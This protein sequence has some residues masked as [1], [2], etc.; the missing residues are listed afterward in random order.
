ML[1]E[2]HEALETR[3]LVL[4]L[5]DASRR[6]QLEGIAAQV[7]T[8]RRSGTPAARSTRRWASEDEFLFGLIRGLDCP[9]FL[10]LT[11]IDLVAKDKLLPLIESLTQQYNFAEVIP[12]SAR[13]RDGLDVLVRKIVERAAHGRALLS[14]RSIHRS[15]AALHGG[16][17]DSRTHSGRDR[18]RGSVRLGGGDRAV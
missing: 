10:V 8:C 14:Q 16:R 18:R 11:K 2:V 15:A 4:V 3:D 5:M 12:V 17:A 6:V 1:Q 7:E 9:V 13:K